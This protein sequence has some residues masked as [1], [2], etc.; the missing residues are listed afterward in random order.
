MANYESLIDLSIE[1]LNEHLIDTSAYDSIQLI[2]MVD[3]QNVNIDNLI[4]INDQIVPIIITDY[5]GMSNDE[6]KSMYESI[7]A[8]HEE[9]K[10]NNGNGANK[11][12]YKKDTRFFHDLYTLT[13]DE[14]E[15]LDSLDEAVSLNFNYKIR[16][17]L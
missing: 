11:R 13:Y 15:N 7:K 2:N 5:S 9:Y 16:G 8:R 14:N 3:K 1:N 10:L 4:N 6:L 12:H 17:L